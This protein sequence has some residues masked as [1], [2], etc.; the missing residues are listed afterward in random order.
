[1]TSLCLF[2]LK[3]QI[4]NNVK[5][6]TKSYNKTNALGRPIVF[7]L[8]FRGLVTTAKCFPEG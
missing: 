6:P 7:I 3:C 2:E 5:Y 8:W 1:M 4:Q